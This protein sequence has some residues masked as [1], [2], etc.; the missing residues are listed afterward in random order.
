MVLGRV[1]RGGETFVIENPLAAVR[2]TA[3]SRR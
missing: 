2:A 3:A 1:S